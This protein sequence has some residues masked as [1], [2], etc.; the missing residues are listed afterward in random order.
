MH[1]LRRA[2]CPCRPTTTRRLSCRRH[3]PSFIYQHRLPPPPSPQSAWSALAVPTL[4]WP[5]EGGVGAA[6]VG[7]TSYVGGGG[8]EVILVTWGEVVGGGEVIGP[9]L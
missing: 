8:W 5:S 4:A 2:V 6:G 9:T 1:V 3:A 7:D